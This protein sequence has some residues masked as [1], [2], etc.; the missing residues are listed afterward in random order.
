MVSSGGGASIQSG[1]FTF[2]ILSRIDATLAKIDD[3]SHFERF[4]KSEEEVKRTVHQ[5][6]V[7]LQME[8]SQSRR[9]SYL[10]A[11]QSSRAN[12]E[13]WSSR[14][15]GRFEAQV[16]APAAPRLPLHLRPKEEHSNKFQ[17]IHEETSREDDTRAAGVRD[18]G[19]GGK[20]KK[21]R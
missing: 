4:Y 9:M 1:G 19:K 8:P 12:T 7:H 15:G 3:D 14:Q 16:M 18:Q 6:E 17:K 2:R 5:P 21:R 10:A 11:I 20:G 13:C